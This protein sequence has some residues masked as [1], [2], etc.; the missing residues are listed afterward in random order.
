MRIALSDGAL[1]ALCVKRISKV[2]KQRDE[3]GGQQCYQDTVLNLSLCGQQADGYTKRHH[4][5]TTVHC[6]FLNML[7]NSLELETD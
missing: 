1:S 2:S 7:L 3:E 6:Y 5:T 4:P